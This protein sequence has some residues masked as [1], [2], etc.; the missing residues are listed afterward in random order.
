MC[1]DC[2]YTFIGLWMLISSICFPGYRINDI[3]AGAV[4]AAMAGWAGVEFGRHLDW[5]VAV[6]G[7][8]YLSAGKVLAQNPIVLRV[9]SIACG[10]F[11]IAA[12]FWPFY[13]G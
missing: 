11:A 2:A 1:H 12:S 6:A 5:A 10:L 13:F 8:L 4:L 3:L 7:L 9:S